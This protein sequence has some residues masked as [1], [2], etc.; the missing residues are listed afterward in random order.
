MSNDEIFLD[1]RAVEL[2]KEVIGGGSGK[3]TVVINYAE[4]NGFAKEY[5]QFPENDKIFA[6]DVEVEIKTVEGS[7][8][9]EGTQYI[10]VDKDAVISFSLTH[11]DKVTFNGVE[12][13]NPTKD[14][15]TC[16]L[17]GYLEFIKF[18]E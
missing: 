4:D 15:A 10:E 5:V 11:V 7:T 1:E 9:Y 3:L 2:T 16:T 6:N 13:A 8:G 12:I 14:T 17:G 18:V